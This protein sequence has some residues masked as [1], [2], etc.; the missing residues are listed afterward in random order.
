MYSGGGLELGW[1][2]AVLIFY[3]LFF[4]EI[5][6]LVV[7]I[8]TSISSLLHGLSNNG[9]KSGAVSFVNREYPLYYVFSLI[10][11]SL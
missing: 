11:L 7:F 4:L 1:D 5:W 2:L 6:D 9:T 10:Y 3:F 8:L